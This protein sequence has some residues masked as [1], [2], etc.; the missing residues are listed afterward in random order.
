M[1][2]IVPQANIHVDLLTP[3]IFHESWWLDIATEGRYEVVEV[4]QNGEVLGRL[5]YS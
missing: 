4:T 3:T 5:P 2:Q 1:L